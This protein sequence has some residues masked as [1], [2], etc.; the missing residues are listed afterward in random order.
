[1]VLGGP[2]TSQLASNSKLAGNGTV[3]VDQHFGVLEN[4]WTRES[5]ED[6]R[7]Y[8]FNRATGSSQWHLPNDFY[9]SSVLAPAPPGQKNDGESQGTVVFPTTAKATLRVD[10]VTEVLPNSSQDLSPIGLVE[11]NPRDADLI[12]EHLPG[13]LAE[14]LKSEKFEEDCFDKF[15]VAA[16]DCEDARRLEIPDLYQTIQELADSAP[17][18]VSMDGD[19]IEGLARKYDAGGSGTLD[20]Q[21]L[22]EFSRF[23][24]AMRYLDATANDVFA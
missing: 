6:G 20:A 22:M 4:V 17:I 14:Y 19:V 3:S 12:C 16:S 21:E 18:A 15:I 13:K 9:E 8:Y 10:C 2:S 7:V 23:A 24:I 5:G 1:M 11:Q